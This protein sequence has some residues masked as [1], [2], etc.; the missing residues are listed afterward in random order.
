[1]AHALTMDSQRAA[2]ELYQILRELDPSRWRADLAQTMRPRIEMLRSHM[3]ELAHR[4]DTPALSSIRERL[5]ELSHVLEHTLPTADRVHVQQRWEDFRLKVS[6]AYERLAASLNDLDIHIPSLRPTN[7]ARN[8]F[9]IGNALLCLCLI[10]L[11]LDVRTAII[12]TICAATLAWTM[13]ISR[14]FVPRINAM[15]MWFFS[16][17]AH[18][19][20]AWRVNSA[21]W[22][23]TALVI[24]A[25]IQDLTIASTAIIVL[26]FADPAAAVIGRR[27]GQVKL[28]HGRSLEGTGTF[29]LV[30]T[31]V[32]FLWLHLAHDF[33]PA[34]AVT[35]ALGGTLPGALA[36]LFSRRIDD[37]LSIPVSVA[38]GL[39]LTQA[40]IG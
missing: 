29:V 30:G 25:L 3:R 21:T 33:A 8:I 5:R 32:A 12:A 26:G 38:V 9:H 6:P 2:V 24:L 28:I 1:L 18:P 35:W 22:Y 20:E 16:P 10:H 19:H 15:L 36:E 31:L 39:L 17:F 40:L 11:V 14:R 7:Y 13:E 27:F 37:N 4:A 34:L 23:S